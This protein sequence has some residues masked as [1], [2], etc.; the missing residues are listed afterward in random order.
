MHKVICRT[1][2]K[3]KD[4]EMHSKTLQKNQMEWS[5]PDSNKRKIAGKSPDTWKLNNTLLQNNS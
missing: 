4:K 3:K 1:T 2:T 5:Q